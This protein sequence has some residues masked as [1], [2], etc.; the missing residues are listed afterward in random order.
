MSVKRIRTDSKIFFPDPYVVRIEY[1]D[2]FYTN[3]EKEYNKITRQA[4]KLFK[5]TWGY[6]NLGIEQFKAPDSDDYQVRLRAYL[7]FAETGDALQ[8]RLTHDSI[9]VLM[10]P[11][12]CRFTIHQVIEIDPPIVSTFVES[13]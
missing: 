7:C 13:I 6:S 1:S 8:F 10:W 4:Y 3:A 12:A 9:R 2:P 11:S 5:G